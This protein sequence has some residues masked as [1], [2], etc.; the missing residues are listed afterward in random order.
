MN[1]DPP[2]EAEVRKAAEQ[3]SYRDFIVVALI[4]NR[5]ELFPDNWI[6]VHD[7]EVKVGRIENFNNWTRE[8][9]S[10][11]GVTCLEFEYFCSKGDTFWKKSDEEILMVAKLE[12]EKLGVANAS[13]VLDGCV[14]RVE[15]AYPVY[16]AQYRKSVDVIRSALS[17]IENLQVVGRNGMHKYNNQDHSMFT[18]ILAAR[19]LAGEKHDVW[20]VNTD[21]EYHEEQGNESGRQ[22]PQ[23]V[24]GES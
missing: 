15:K 2:L 22:M 14:V 8:M 24:S 12:M 20:R 19:N 17:E 1:I 6:Y 23:A 18:G 16:D 4:V 21:A 5:T 13:E 9:V 7:P 3:L 10:K 11:P